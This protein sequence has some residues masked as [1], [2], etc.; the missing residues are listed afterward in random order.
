M[1]MIARI[2]VILFLVVF[3][4]EAST[5]GIWPSKNDISITPFKNYKEL[6]YLINPSDEDLYVDVSFVCKNKD[7]KNFFRVYYPESLIL[8]KFSTFEKPRPILIVFQGNFFI[9]DNFVLFNKSLDYYKISSGKNKFTCM[10]EVR[11][12]EA[13]PVIL[14]S[15]FDIESKGFDFKKIA[16][17]FVLALFYFIFKKRNSFF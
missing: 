7:Y 1:G 3:S 11:T 2:L 8:P 12:Q 16:L 4:L 15:V 17:F 10:L 14:T 13:T 6:V 5:I 9:K